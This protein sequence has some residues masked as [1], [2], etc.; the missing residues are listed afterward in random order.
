M[1]DFDTVVLPPP[2]GRKN[3]VSGIRK[4]EKAKVRKPEPKKEELKTLL[5]GKPLD[6]HTVKIIETEFDKLKK[7]IEGIKCK[8]IRF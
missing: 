8:F 1:S 5:S 2:K 7:L 3:A 6:E 4:V